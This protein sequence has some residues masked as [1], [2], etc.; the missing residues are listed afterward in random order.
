LHNETHLRKDA[1]A[2]MTYNDFN[3]KQLPVCAIAHLQAKT[4]CNKLRYGWVDIMGTAY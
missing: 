2:Q 1:F 3:Y 4:K